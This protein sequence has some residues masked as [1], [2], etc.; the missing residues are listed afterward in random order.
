MGKI[1]LGRVILGG[2]VSGVVINLV[3]GI[4]NGVILDPQWTAVRTGLG[5]DPSMSIKQIVA[6]N[7][8]GFA[9]GF[10]IVWLYAAMRPRLG[11]GPKTAACAGLVVWAAAWALGD[12]PPVFLHV[13]PVGLIGILVAVGVVETMVAGIAGAYFYKEQA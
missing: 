7:L 4:M 2:L 11:A 13:F 9:A 8:W 5:K 10:L 12:A 1:N 3:E 6:F